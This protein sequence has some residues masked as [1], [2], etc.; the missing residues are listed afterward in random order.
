ML[1]ELVSHHIWWQ[2]PKSLNLIKQYYAFEPLANGPNK[3]YDLR[4]LVRHNIQW[5]D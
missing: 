1:G 2:T 3:L 4:E 5:Y